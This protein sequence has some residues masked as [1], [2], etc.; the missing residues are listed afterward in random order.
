LQN[1]LQSY[2]AEKT[3]STTAEE[4]SSTSAEKINSTIERDFSDDEN[5][6]SNLCPSCG[7]YSANFSVCK[8][9]ERLQ[10]V[11]RKRVDL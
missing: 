4:T 5:A 2:A 8:L 3:N 10:C 7:Q 11:K 6:E 9:C 1:F